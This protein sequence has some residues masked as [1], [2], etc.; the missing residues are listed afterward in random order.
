MEIKPDAL[1]CVLNGTRGCCDFG[2]LYSYRWHYNA[3]FISPEVISK[4]SVERSVA[5]L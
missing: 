1:A 2:A 5:D 4:V 3:G